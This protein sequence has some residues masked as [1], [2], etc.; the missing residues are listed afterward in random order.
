MKLSNGIKL[1]LLPRFLTSQ[2]R[3]YMKLRRLLFSRRS[4]YGYTR[5][6]AAILTLYAIAEIL[7]VANPL[8]AQAQDQNPL[9]AHRA[10]FPTGDAT[11]TVTIEPLDPKAAEELKRLKPE[12]RK[13]LEEARAARPQLST[14]RIVRK[15]LLRRDIRIYCS[16]PAAE[17]W[18]TDSGMVAMRLKPGDRVSV[19]K[20]GN[21]LDDRFDGSIFS[22]VSASSFKSEETMRGKQCRRYEVEI[23]DRY[24]ERR[25]ILAWIEYQ[26][27]RPFAWSDGDSVY[28]FNYDTE[29][30]PNSLTIPDD[31]QKEL[32]RIKVFFKPPTALPPP[33]RT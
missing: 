24:D 17:Y 10:N 8:P 5:A 29:P 9:A 23:I 11:W 21:L 33:H 7:D 26:N 12:T 14:I 25:T 1:H 19:M 22:F 20:S 18:W 28:L 6:F 3:T 31:F 27:S 32:N 2:T 30:L 13:K 16:G 4:A 15:A